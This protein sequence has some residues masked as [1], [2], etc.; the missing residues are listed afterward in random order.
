MRVSMHQR[1]NVKRS[2][3][4]DQGIYLLPYWLLVIGP[5]C[6]SFRP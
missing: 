5:A 2:G 6:L 4:R 3:R 1:G